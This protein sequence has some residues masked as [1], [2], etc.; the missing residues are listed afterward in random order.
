MESSVDI[1]LHKL[2]PLIRQY[3]AIKR[4]VGDAI[5]FFRLGDFYEMFNEDAVDASKLLGILLT[6]KSAGTGNS[7]PLAGVPAHSA[8]TY[9]ARLVKAGRKVA[10]CEQVGAADPAGAKSKLMD[11]AVI[12]IVTPGTLVEENLL[13]PNM[14]NFLGALARVDGQVGLACV[15]ISTGDF[16]VGQWPEG[17]DTFKNTFD[18][19]PLR[20]LVAASDDT[21]PF[22]KAVSVPVSTRRPL[23]VEE[24]L[25][26]L[27][28]QFGA[29]M[30]EASGLKRLPAA[31]SA[32]G[33]IF[34]YLEETRCVQLP[35]RFP[36]IFSGD[37][38]MEL[39]ASTLRNLEILAGISGD[40]NAGLLSVIDRTKTAMGSRLLRRW[41]LAPLRRSAD[42]SRRQDCVA[43]LS[44][45]AGPLDA[46][47]TALSDIGDLE[48]ILSRLAR[49]ATARVADLVTLRRSVESL[50]KVLSELLRLTSASLFDPAAFPDLSPLRALLQDR[51]ADS[52]SAVIGDGKVIKPGVHAELDELKELLEN[53]RLHLLKFQDA[54]RARSGVHSLKVTYNKIYGYYIEISKTH[55]ASVPAD[56]IRKQTLV[57][58]ER[59]ITPELKRFEEKL[60]AAADRIASIEREL[61][62]QLLSDVLHHAGPVR[63]AADL[64][65]RVD[66]LASLA[67][68][69]RRERFVRPALTEEDILEIKDGR[70]PVVERFC[71]DGFVPNDTRLTPDRRL[72]IVTGPNMAGKSTFIRQTAVLTLLAQIGSFVP[73]ASMRWRPVD[74]IFTRIGAS[75]DLSR[76][77]S[78]FFV[79]MSETAAIL[80]QATRDSLI[81]LD[82]IGRGTS[83]YDGLSI[84][85]AVVE[86]IA[87]ALSAKT[88][89]ATHYHE[90]ADLAG[91][92][93]I[94]TLTVMVREWEGRVVFLR[95]VTDGAS[96]RSFGI[97]V[98]DLAGIPRSVLERARVL[99][100]DLE[101]GVAAA[102]RRPKDRGQADLFSSPVDVATEDLKRRILGLTLDQMTPVDVMSAVSQ[103]QKEFQREP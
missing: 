34:R 81:L 82:E 89:F 59:Y 15:D 91:R 4:S 57:N 77:Q 2:T 85:W 84:A 37:D 20:E 74:R 35:L 28:G 36:R 13:V 22:L 50:P 43:A 49:P 44:E 60:L 68:T 73:A 46:L 27:G 56:Y 78:T 88:L 94:H 29:G 92:S 16:Q 63:A 47:R 86:H 33:L 1:R 53:Q 6:K 51:L 42:I 8:D 72:A 100:T 52:P 79:E 11:R 98:A 99:L 90:L 55:A 66:A 7:V 93:G 12:R 25:E 17:S 10:I 30:V 38:A 76:G 65:A 14:D 39:D 31:L 61:V 9:I 87:G 40:P 32:V 95:K 67:E 3:Q 18:L 41:I 21:S 24:T 101:S 58:A 23:G 75:D 26:A 5:L 97:A 96:D 71:A 62:L 69:A 48:R 70:H 80:R 102:E 103:W 45:N 54:E 19:I 64:V 83:T